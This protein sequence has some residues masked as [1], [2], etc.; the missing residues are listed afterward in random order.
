MMIEKFKKRYGLLFKITGRR[1]YRPF[2]SGIIYNNHI[3][4]R[5]NGRT[6]DVN[7]EEFNGIVKLFCYAKKI[8]EHLV[9]TTNE[10]DCFVTKEEAE[11]EYRRRNGNI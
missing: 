7:L 10:Q 9:E 4:V 6:C 5:H 1:F 2:L 8:E 3:E 11:Q